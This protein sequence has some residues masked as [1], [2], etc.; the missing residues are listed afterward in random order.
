MAKSVL[1]PEQFI[2]EVNR[3]LPGMYGYK[4]GMRAFLVPEGA[5]GA[6]AT[7]YDF[8]PSDDLGTVGAGKAASDSVLREYDVNPYISRK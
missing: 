8:T 6:T 3:R 5:T 7:G 2:D 4:P 1:S